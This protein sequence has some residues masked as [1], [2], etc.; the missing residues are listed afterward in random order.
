MVKKRFITAGMA[1]LILGGIISSVFTVSWFVRK[2]DFE[3]D[4]SQIHIGDS[5]QKVVQLYG[6]PEETCDC[7]EFKRPSSL[8]VIQKYCV[9][10]YWYRSFLQ[11]WIFFFD[12][13]GKLIHKAYNV[14]Y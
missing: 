4:Y 9:K 14:S 12:K 6:Q 2:K 3:N 1:V 10:V 11:Q 8:E 7:S 5:E 13:D